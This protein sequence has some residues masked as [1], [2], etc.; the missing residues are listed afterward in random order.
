[1]PY[2]NHLVCSLAAGSVAARNRE[3]CASRARPKTRK[4]N[5]IQKG[6]ARRTCVIG[7]GES[8]IT[9][10]ATPMGR[11][12]RVQ[13]GVIRP[14]GNVSKTSNTATWYAK[15]MANPTGPS[16]KRRVALAREL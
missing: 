8:L 13:R 16:E 7:K 5:R 11:Y 1:M 3:Y 6:E 15:A 4:S 10:H 2:T 12:Q 14:S 9:I